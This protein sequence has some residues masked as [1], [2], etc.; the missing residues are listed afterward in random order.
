MKRLLLVAILFATTTT[1]H[2]EPT[3]A[4]RHLMNEPATLFDL[5]MLRLQQKFRKIALD[6][7]DLVFAVVSYD[8]DTNRIK[9]T[10]FA[11]TEKIKT[12]EGRKQGCRKVL[13]EIKQDL[14][15]DLETGR[16]KGPNSFVS[17]LFSHVDYSR[18]GW[19]SDLV[20]ELDNM[21]ELTA[22]V[23]GQTGTGAL[24]RSTLLGT[25]ILFTKQAK[26]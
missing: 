4:V 19:P 10:A 5:G 18:R 25:E 14:G 16:P 24:C 17:N 12:V 21:V 11:S 8:W 23:F 1:G 26:R 9:I 13:K 2:T 3:P 15:I 22:R 6:D 7:F 20:D